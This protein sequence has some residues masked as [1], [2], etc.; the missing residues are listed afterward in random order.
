MKLTVYELRRLI[1]EVEKDTEG[2]GEVLSRV[3]GFLVTGAVDE[4]VDRIRGHLRTHIRDV[5][6]SDAAAREALEKAE[7]VLQELAEEANALV[8][9]RLYEFIQSGL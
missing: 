6:Q 1:R 2:E 5:S 4:F 9:E 3:P 8:R 7:K